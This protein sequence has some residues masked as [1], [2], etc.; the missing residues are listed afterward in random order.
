MSMQKKDLHSNKK[1]KKAVKM[2]KC[3]TC[4]KETVNRFRCATCLAEVD[5]YFEEYSAEGLP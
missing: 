5:A 3:R 4:G 2:Y 1:A